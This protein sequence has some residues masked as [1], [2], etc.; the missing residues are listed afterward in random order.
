M[1]ILTTPK[2]TGLLQKGV[3]NMKNNNDKIKQMYESIDTPDYDVKDKVLAEINNQKRVPRISRKVLLVATMVMILLLATAGAAGAFDHMF[4]VR[5]I[6]T[7]EE[8]PTISPTPVPGMDANEINNINNAQPT[9]EPS[10]LQHGDFVDTLIDFVY[11]A[12]YGEYR[13]IECYDASGM[14]NSSENISPFETEDY[15]LM[16]QKVNNSTFNISFPEYIPQ[17]YEFKLG[18][19]EFYMDEKVFSIKPTK[20]E[21]NGFYYTIYN[22]PDDFDK[23]IKDCCMIFENDSE[24]IIEFRVIL[25]PEMSGVEDVYLEDDVEAEYIKVDGFDDAVLLT[26]NSYFKGHTIALYKS[27]EP[28]TNIYH[29]VM[30]DDFL[31]QHGRTQEDYAEAHDTVIIYVSSPTLPKEELIK[32]A[33]GLN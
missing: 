9:K 3:N 30:D 24:D 13:M 29:T 1:I 6:S 27:I 8:G 26:G 5:D 32:F 20:W 16:M 19:L 10:T 2:V 12:E 18:R 14:V 25:F 28:I 23:N 11:Q 31:Q 21:E 17:G 4:I 7:I 15:S 22:L 33:Q